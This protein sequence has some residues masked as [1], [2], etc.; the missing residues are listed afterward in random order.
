MSVEVCQTQKIGP[1][2]LCKHLRRVCG[3]T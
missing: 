3:Q 1:T 2:Y